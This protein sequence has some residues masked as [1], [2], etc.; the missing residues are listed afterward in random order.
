MNSPLTGAQMEM[1]Y[2]TDYQFDRPMAYMEMSIP[3]AS[4]IIGQNYVHAGL[5]SIGWEL[6]CAAYMARV[7]LFTLGFNMDEI[8]LFILL[9]EAQLCELTWHTPTASEKALRSLQRRT[10]AHFES[11]KALSS[12]H[13]ICVADVDYRRRNGKP[14]VLVSLKSSDQFRQYGKFDQALI[15]YAL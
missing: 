10:A 4:A 12:R 14:G 7:A 15:P 6:Q 5:D 2:T 11:L 1:R 13:D 9:A 8:E 3:L